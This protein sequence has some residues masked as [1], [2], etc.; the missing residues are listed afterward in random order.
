MATDIK[1]DITYT[2]DLLRVKVSSIIWDDALYRQR[3][4]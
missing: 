2:V 3:F 4:Y 1:N